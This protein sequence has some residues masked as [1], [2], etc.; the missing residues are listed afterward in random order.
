MSDTKSTPTGEVST[1]SSPKGWVEVLQVIAVLCGGTAIALAL[2]DL[3]DKWAYFVLALACLGT[4]FAAFRLLKKPDDPS[5]HRNQKY[6][7]TVERLMTLKEVGTPRDIRSALASIAPFEGKLSDLR[8]QLYAIIGKPR[9]E[10]QLTAILPY[11]QV[12]KSA[13]ANDDQEDMP[14]SSSIGEISLQ[15]RG[16]KSDSDKG[17]GLDREIA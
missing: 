2:A 4:G 6:T 14:S 9:G 13:Q 1:S 15:Q 16:E 12:Y 11:L 3:G 17:K 10:P 7:V 8:E 5:W